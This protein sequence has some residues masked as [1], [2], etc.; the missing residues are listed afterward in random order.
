MKTLI[1]FIKFHPCLNI[2]CLEAQAGIPKRNLI[3]VVKGY[4]PFPAKHVWNLTKV[5]CQYGLEIDGWRF[6]YDAEGDTFFLEC[7][8]D[9]APE[10][11][12]HDTWIEYRVPMY[13]DAISDD[14]GLIE[15]LK[16]KEEEVDYSDS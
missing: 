11:I 4:R 12:E 13:R 10:L 1:N 15:F 14:Q 3:D 2:T 9:Q 16:E 7:K 5:L 8:M 6:S